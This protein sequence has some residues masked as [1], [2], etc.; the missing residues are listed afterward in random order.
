MYSFSYS[1]YFKF[2]NNLKI[3]IYFSFYDTGAI[4]L[5]E[6]QNYGVIC[7]THQK[8]FAIDNETSFFISEL[9]NIDN[10]NIAFNKIMDIIEKIS[11]SNINTE[12]IAKKNQIINKCENS[13]IDLCKSLS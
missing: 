8:E 3:I 10:I 13:L 4:G 5:K 6:I 12:L 2:F 7:F 1:I 11:K 9:A